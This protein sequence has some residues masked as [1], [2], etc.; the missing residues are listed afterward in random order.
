MNL[1]AF[2]TF[3][4]IANFVIYISLGVYIWALTEFSNLS[5]WDRIDIFW[6]YLGVTMLWNGFNVFCL[7]LISY[8]I[9]RDG[10]NI[11]RILGWPTLQQLEINKINKRI[12]KIEEKIGLS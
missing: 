1:R 12:S 4:L 2:I 11:K 6:Q 8:W 3:A 9:Y 5:A 7:T 10:E